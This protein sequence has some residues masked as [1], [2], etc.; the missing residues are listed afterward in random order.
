MNKYN[1]IL[2]QI[3]ALVPGSRFANLVKAYKTEHGAKGL[4]SRAHFVATLFG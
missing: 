4:T 3:L 1:T 2:G